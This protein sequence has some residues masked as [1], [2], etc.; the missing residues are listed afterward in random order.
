[1][2]RW[3]K[4]GWLR[5]CLSCNSALL[6]T[7]ASASRVATMQLLIAAASIFDDTTAG[8]TQHAAEGAGWRCA[9]GRV[10][11]GWIVGEAG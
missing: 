7:L 1:M 5:T 10:G 8:L 2:V 4:G 11:N 6:R 9:S 3:E